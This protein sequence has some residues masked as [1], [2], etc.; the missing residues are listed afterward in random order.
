MTKL[1]RNEGKKVRDAIG[2]TMQIWY[3]SLRFT[4]EVRLTN[5]DH[6]D[7]NGISSAIFRIN[8]LRRKAKELKSFSFFFF[9][10]KIEN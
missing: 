5:N 4:V 10:N 8:L 9:F 6:Y 2:G 1:K 7:Y 3:D